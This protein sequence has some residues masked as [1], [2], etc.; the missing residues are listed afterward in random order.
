[1][2][3]V[4]ISVGYIALRSERSLKSTALT[5]EGVAAPSIKIPRVVFNTGFF[6]E[7]DEFL[8]ELLQSVMLLLIGD[9]FPHRVTN[10]GAH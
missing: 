4:A 1:M 3:K 8:V 2:E 5:P 6:Q 9:V 10:R 7:L